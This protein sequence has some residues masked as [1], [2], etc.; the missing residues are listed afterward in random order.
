MHRQTKT[1]TTQQ[2]QQKHTPHSSAT[3]SNQKDP[4]YKTPKPTRQST[5]NI[6]KSNN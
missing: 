6:R 3:N 1:N 5:A 4:N 2:T